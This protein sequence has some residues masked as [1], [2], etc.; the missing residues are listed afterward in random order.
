M[1]LRKRW[2]KLPRKAKAGVLIKTPAETTRW[3]WQDLAALI[4]LCGEN[5]RLGTKRCGE[6]DAQAYLAQVNAMKRLFARLAKQE[7]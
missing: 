3:K 6:H 4:H 1:R 5:V 7:F 2:R